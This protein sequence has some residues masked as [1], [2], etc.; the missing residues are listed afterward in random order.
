[1]NLQDVSRDFKSTLE[2]EIGLDEIST[3]NLYTQTEQTLVHLLLL[4]HQFLLIRQ[5]HELFCAFRVHEWS[6]VKCYMI[7]MLNHQKLT[8]PRIAS[9]SQ[10]SSS[11][12]RL[13]GNA[14]QRIKLRRE[15]QQQLH[16]LQDKIEKHQ[17]LTCSVDKQKPVSSIEKL[18]RDWKLANVDHALV[19]YIHQSGVVKTQDI[20]FDEIFPKALLIIITIEIGHRLCCVGLIELFFSSFASHRSSL[21]KS[22]QKLSSSPSSEDKLGI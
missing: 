22:T 11:K 7:M 18:R 1:M 13:Q 12:L 14:K 19:F 8:Q 6:L 2:R 9:R 21:R 4:H 3:P 17:D 15:K 16:P 5:D 10:K 20:V